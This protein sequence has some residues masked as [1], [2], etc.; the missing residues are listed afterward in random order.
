MPYFFVGKD[1]EDQLCEI[2]RVLGT[3]D[4]NNYLQSK[5]IKMESS[6]KKKIPNCQRR[7]FNQFINDDNKHLVTQEAL[8]LLDKTLVIDHEN[9]LTI[10]EVLQHPF[11]ESFA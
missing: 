2:V 9:R 10:K 8:D 6:Y 5:D 3:E 4:L 11:F 1:N 7:S